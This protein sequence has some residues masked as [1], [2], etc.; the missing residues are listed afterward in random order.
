MSSLIP[1][2]A[3]KGVSQHP[4]LQQQMNVFALPLDILTDLSVRSLQVPT[5][6]PATPPTSSSVEQILPPP[7][8]TAE[9][10]DGR[11][12]CGVCPGS[13]FE[14]VEEQRT[15]FKE[16]WHRYNVRVKMALAGVGEHKKGKGKVVSKDEFEGMV[17]GQF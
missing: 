15:H 1:L 6:T 4:R 10:S 14:D 11:L 9:S 5:P 17:D 16:D 3:T 2:S 12:V 8:S 13:R 7:A